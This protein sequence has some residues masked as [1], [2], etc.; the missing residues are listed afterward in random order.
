MFE[1]EKGTR[2][3]G[4]GNIRKRESTSGKVG[5]MRQFFLLQKDAT[6]LS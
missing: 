6:L 1:P 2:E 4:E 5:A 3:G